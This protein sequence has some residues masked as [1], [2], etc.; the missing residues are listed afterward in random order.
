MTHPADIASDIP[1][2]LLSLRPKTDMNFDTPDEFVIFPMLQ[3]LTDFRKQSHIMH[4][5]WNEPHGVGDFVAVSPLVRLHNFTFV[6]QFLAD[7]P[8]CGVLAGRYFLG[9][10]IAMEYSSNLGG[11]QLHF[12]SIDNMENPGFN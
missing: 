1:R 4:A 11:T 8:D 5:K 12:R 2:D 10:L 7:N 6:K 3:I 9:F